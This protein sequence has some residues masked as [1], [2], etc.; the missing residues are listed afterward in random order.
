MHPVH[1]NLLAI[2]APRRTT[3][4]TPTGHSVVGASVAT[5]NLAN[6]NDAPLHLLELQD[7]TN[8]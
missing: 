5:Y 3:L 8:S 7:C 6:H 1:L 2:K 4:H